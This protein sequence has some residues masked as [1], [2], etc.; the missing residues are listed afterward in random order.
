MR[1]RG[2]EDAPGPGGD[3]SGDPVAVG[4]RELGKDDVFARLDLGDEPITAAR[5]GRYHRAPRAEELPHGATEERREA[6][7]LADLVEE[8]QVDRGLWRE[9]AARDRFERAEID[10]VAADAVRGV[11]VR[12]GERPALAVEGLEEKAAP[13]RPFA[14]LSREEAPDADL[15]QQGRSSRERGRLARAGTASQQ[16]VRGLAR[17]AL[18]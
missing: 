12:P 16:D 3:P 17:G 7:H 10:P 11:E 6:L 14:D 2:C 9:R 4:G 15:G 18:P 8:E 13:G 1:S 5:H